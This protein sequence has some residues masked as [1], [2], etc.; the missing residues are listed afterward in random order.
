VCKALYLLV[1]DLVFLE[2]LGVGPGRAVVEDFG[3]SR[4]INA[5]KKQIRKILS[6]LSLQLTELELYSRP[7]EG[8]KDIVTPLSMI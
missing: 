5:R 7:V 8:A 4:C 1:N 3:L 6:K 2:V